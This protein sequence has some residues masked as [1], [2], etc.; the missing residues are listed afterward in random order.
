[1]RK[2][3][4]IVIIA[5]LIPLMAL[6]QKEQI[7]NPGFEIWE[8][9][10]P[11]VP[12]LEPENWSSIK[13]SDDTTLAQ[14]APLVW[15][16]SEDAHSGNY[17]VYL[18][19]VYNVWISAGIA[20]T[21]TNGRTHAS[22]F[23]SEGYAFTQ[24]DDPQWHTPFQSRPDSLVGWFKC[25]PMEGDTGGIRAIIHVDEGKMPANG[26]EP[27]WIAEANHKFPGYAVTEW[28]RFSVP[29]EYYSENASTFLL[30]VI[31]A[32]NGVLAIENSE[33]W[34]DDL[35]M[36]YNDPG[37]I[38][39]LKGEETILYFHDGYLNLKA[40]APDFFNNSTLYLHDLSGK[41]V[42]EQKITG[43]RIKPEAILEK[44]IYIAKI[45]S[46]SEI[47]TQ[48]IYIY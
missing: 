44:G 13:T 14:A 37:G 12:E 5:L 2:Q 17:S 40:M 11:W 30:I 15:G 45:L 35:E 3:L 48:K 33:L 47:M 36:I 18:F 6:S 22:V 24:A 41:L 19:N 23:P 46:G 42:F 39:D 31:K 9:A 1:M 32:G 26:T 27:N 20:G 4:Y 43:D 21:L 38:S 7:E 28:T 34:L 29:F 25:N 10:A 8:N 16:M